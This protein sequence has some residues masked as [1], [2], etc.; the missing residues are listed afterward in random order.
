MRENFERIRF[1]VTIQKLI[2]VDGSNAF[3]TFTPSRSHRLSQSLN[4][5]T[6]IH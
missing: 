3:R 6:V 1:R 5:W 4:I 2:A